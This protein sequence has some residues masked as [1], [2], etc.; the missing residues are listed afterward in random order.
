MKSKSNKDSPSIPYWRLIQTLSSPIL[1]YR[2]KTSTFV[3]ANQEA[4]TRLEIPPTKLAQ[5]NSLDQLIRDLFPQDFSAQWEQAI[6]NCQKESP[7]LFRSPIHLPSGTRFYSDVSFLPFEEQEESW[8][9]VE[10]KNSTKKLASENDFEPFFHLQ[11]SNNFLIDLHPPVDASVEVDKQVE[12]IM[13]AGRMTAANA[14]AI[15]LFGHQYSKLPL[16]NI[17]SHSSAHSTLEDCLRS[18]V[19]NGHQTLAEW[20]SF[21]INDAHRKWYLQ[22]LSGVLEDGKLIRI[23]GTQVDVTADKIRKIQYRT[24][25]E[26]FPNGL[27][28][29]Y[30]KELRYTVINGEGLRA[31]GM[32]S[33]DLEGKRLRDIFPPE[34][35]ERDEVALRAALEGETTKSMVSFGNELFKV[36]TLPVL[37]KSGKVISGLVMSQNV[38]TTVQTEKKWQDTV[39]QLQL[40]IDT[41]QLGIWYLDQETQQLEWND[42]LLEIYGLTREQFEEDLQAW[43]VQLHPDDRDYAN[44]R[45]QKIQEGETVYDVEFRIIRPD[46]SIRYINASGRPA[47]DADGA[48]KGWMGINTDVTSIKEREAF[49]SAIFDNSLLA[50][51]VANDK[52]DYL[53]VN[54]AACELFGFDEKT[55]LSLNVKDI[56]ILGEPGGEVR[57][58][59]YVGNGREIGELSFR[60][61][62]GEIK[63]VQYHATR[64]EKDFNLSILADISAQKEAEMAR[65]RANELAIKNKELERFAYLASHD[66]QEPLRT[67]SAF[68][69]LLQSRFA[70]QLGQPEQEYLDFILQASHRMSAL[71]KGLLAYAKLG[72]DHKIEPIDCQQIVETVCQ[73]LASR[74]SQSGARLE[75]GQLP[76]V[77]G[78]EIGLQMLFQ[79]LISNSLKFRQ[80]EIPPVIKISCQ[81]EGLY[82]IF[83]VEDNGI[84]IDPEFYQR[85]FNIFN[86]LHNQREY[87]G[88]GLGLAHCK[89]IVELLGGDIWLESEPGKGSKFYFSLPR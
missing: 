29:L 44:E 38:T 7:T 25:V 23:L 71:I 83:C 63:A 66:L 59:Q 31:I 68:A 81:E 70:E 26:N 47:Y 6:E 21:D 52:G 35:Y 69:G 3:L 15:Q 84:G 50:I 17:W 80:K 16:S 56:A 14:M 30:D 8:I 77:K 24:M 89:R 75:I 65:N 37:D 34:V 42:K 72:A 64:I 13:A 82:W 39:Q 19:N 53:S 58:A 78:F 62:D 61:P 18:F 33:A 46:G 2:I 27:I 12:A 60:K 74:I 54:P 67:I 45:F 43:Q 22:S 86:R 51:M 10:L 55:F 32:T 76:E 41:A 11:S 87:E 4:L 48:C 36:I 28:A 73:N 49:L 20:V 1:I 85:I 79:N 9:Q 88:S 40:A 57:Y 5:A